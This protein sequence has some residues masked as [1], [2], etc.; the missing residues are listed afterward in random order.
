MLRAIQT[1]CLLAIAFLGIPAYAQIYKW[2][3]ESGTT[4]YSNTPP[5]ADAAA[6]KTTAVADRIS[7]YAPEPGVQ[8]AIG[9]NSANRDRINSDR[10]TALERQLAAERQNSQYAAIGDT[11]AAQAAYAQCLAERR[12]DCDYDYGYGYNPYAYA[13]YGVAVALPVSRH[14]PR[15]HAMKRP[16]AGAG[17]VAHPRAGARLSQSG[18]M[19]Q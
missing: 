7:V 4:N 10:I 13:P 14:R 1:V 5:S 15:H 9:A 16:A 11:S 19:R 8:R 3:D 17:T 18:P 2:V 12:I 6:K